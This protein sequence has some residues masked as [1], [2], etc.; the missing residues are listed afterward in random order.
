MIPITKP[1]LPPYEDVEFAIREIYSSG[2]ITNGKYVRAFEEKAAAYLGVRH[3]VA[4]PSASMALLVLLSTLPPVAE[5]VMPSFTFSATYQALLWNGFTARLV[6]C[7]D[8]CNIDV[9]QVEQ[10]ITP[11]TTAILAVHMYGTATDLEELE[12]VARRNNLLLFFDAAHGFGAKY[13]GRYLGGFGN[14]EVFS[15]GPTKTLPVGEGGLITTNDENLAKRVRS[16]CNHGQPPNSLDSIVKSLNGRLEEINAAIGIRVLD[17]VDKCI[18]RRQELAAMYYNQL[19]GIPGLTFPHVPEY[20]L[21]S[22]KDFC[23]FVDPEQFGM[24]RDQLLAR[25]EKDGI[26]T[27]RY[28][29]PPIHG[30]TVAREH[31]EGVSLPNTEHKASRVLALPMYSHMPYE[32]VTYICRSVR[33]AHQEVR[34]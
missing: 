9:S 31:F 26:Q 19:A 6:D 18:A 11:K 4:A 27:K 34:S 10:A 32:E 29:Y 14:A 25:L 12:A 20:V 5:I 30:L 33:T 13:K 16:A 28:F 23:I 8:S 21:S 22:Y 17:D 1:T 7:N 2:M 24:N 15:L 3:V